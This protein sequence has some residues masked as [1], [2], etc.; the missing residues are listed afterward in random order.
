MSSKLVVN[1]LL[2]SR[3]VRHIDSYRLERGREY[4]SSHNLQNAIN[5]WRIHFPEGKRGIPG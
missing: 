4:G 1:R 2:G 3:K 5:S